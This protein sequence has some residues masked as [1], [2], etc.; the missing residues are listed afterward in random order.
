MIPSTVQ[1][2]DSNECDVRNN[3]AVLAS[4]IVF[5]SPG[6]DASDRLSFGRGMSRQLH[7]STH[8]GTINTVHPPKGPDFSVRSAWACTL[9]VHS[10]FVVVPKEEEFKVYIV[11]G[12]VLCYVGGDVATASV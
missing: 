5:K 10:S 9:M 1:F 6:A 12:R 7:W 4:L 3:L 11:M 8:P 2:V